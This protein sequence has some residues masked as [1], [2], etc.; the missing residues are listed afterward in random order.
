MAAHRSSW[1]EPI[2]AGYRGLEV[3]E[4]PPPTTGIAALMILRALEREDLAAL[5]PRSAERIHLEVEAKRHAFAALHEHV[6]DP[7]F[8]EVPVAALLAG[9]A[10]AAA[11]RAPAGRG[12]G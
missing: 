2:S 11:E 3:F 6:G 9:A 5:G 4:L 12:D 1:V 7:D 10:A 8:V